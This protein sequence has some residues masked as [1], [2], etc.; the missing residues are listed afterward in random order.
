MTEAKLNEK[1]IATQAG[2]ITVHNYD[3]ITREYLSSSLEY[4]AIGV[5]LPANSCT[6]LPGNEKAGSVL[7]RKTDD[8][9]WEYLPDYRGQTIYNTET[10]QPLEIA[11]PGACPDGFTLSK[12]STPFDVW[13]GTAWITDVVALQ[14]SQL[15]DAK[16]LKSELLANAKSIISEWQSEL[17]LGV[18]DEKERASLTSWLAYIKEVKSVDI[19]AAPEIV[20]PMLPVNQAS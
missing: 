2:F 11:M 19:S 16:R 8:S 9:A 3:E 12:P 18:I 20:W 14:S 13:N 7:C 1:L 17:Q 6:E 15:A 4:L 5:G 10:A